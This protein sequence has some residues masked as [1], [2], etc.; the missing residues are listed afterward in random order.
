[1]GLF[2]KTDTEAALRKSIADETALRDELKSRLITAQT[3]ATEAEKSAQK[4]HR[5]LADEATITK[6]EQKQI[7]AGHRVANLSTTL[8]EVE[9]KLADLETRLAAVLEERQRAAN[10]AEIEKHAAD[11]ASKAPD[12]DRALEAVS[13]LTGEI[14]PWLPDAQGL[15]TF[16]TS[17]RGEITAAVSMLQQLLKMHAKA[18]PVF[19]AKPAPKSTFMPPAPVPTVQVC[20]LKPAAYFDINGMVRTASR[21]TDIELP[22]ATAKHAIQIGACCAM[23][24]PRRQTIRQSLGTT[25]G[26][27]LFRNCVQLDQD[28]VDPDR[29]PFA[30]EPIRRSPTLG[31]TTAIDPLFQVVDRGPPRQATVARND[32]D[33]IATRNKGKD[34]P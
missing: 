11:L 34:K 17:A 6:A 27:P 30:P 10:V 7:S 20:V 23:N 28:M 33:A 14:A 21:G 29:E 24:D 3:L 4:L 13:N 16:T 2:S 8:A 1:M 15:H 5:D 19:L 25:I 18:R 22:P 32:L 31:P 26:T 12:L 9:S